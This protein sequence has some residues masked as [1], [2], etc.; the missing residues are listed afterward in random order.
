MLGTLIY[1]YSFEKKKKNF[2]HFPFPGHNESAVLPPSESENS[3]LRLFSFEHDALNFTALRKEFNK[4]RLP[5]NNRRGEN[6]IDK[7]RL[8]L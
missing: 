7:T 8:R 2:N 3:L 1:I 6:R 4:R 5:F